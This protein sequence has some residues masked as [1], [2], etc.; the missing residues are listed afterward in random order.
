MACRA[1]AR[2]DAAQGNWRAAE[3]HLDRAERVARTRSSPHETACNDL[4]A[5]EIDLARGD[6]HGAAARLMRASA[7]FEAMRMHWHLAQAAR[8]REGL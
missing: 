4:A 8:L 5:A 2:L 3:R 7:A 1:M 6:R